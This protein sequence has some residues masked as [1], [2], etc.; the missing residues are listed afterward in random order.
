LKAVSA[1][2][3]GRL[4]LLISVFTI[5]DPVKS[6]FAWRKKTGCVV[7]PVFEVADGR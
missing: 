2:W 3:E 1:A 4:G 7:D 6:G 5:H